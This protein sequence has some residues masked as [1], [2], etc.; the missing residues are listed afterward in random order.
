LQ[1][2]LRNGGVFYKK[3]ADL[4]ILHSG[5]IC[6]NTPTTPRLGLLPLEMAKGNSILLN[7]NGFVN[8]REKVVWA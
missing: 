4:M 6:C 1:K 8:P 7:G 5:Q 2:Y 3:K